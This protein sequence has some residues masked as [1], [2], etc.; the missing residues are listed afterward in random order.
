MRRSCGILLHT[1]TCAEWLVDIL[2]EHESPARLLSW[3]S[4]L[5]ATFYFHS[6]S[7]PSSTS[8]III[9]TQE[10]TPGICHSCSETCVRFT[11][12]L[13]AIA[14][15]TLSAGTSVWA[16]DIIACCVSM[17]IRYI[18][19]ALVHIC[20]QHEHQQQ[21]WEQHNKL[22]KIKKYLR[23]LLQMLTS[24]Q[25]WYNCLCSVCYNGMGDWILSHQIGSVVN[26][27]ITET[28]LTKT[29]IA[30][31]GIQRLNVLRG[32]LGQQYFSYKT[33]NVKL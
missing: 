10:T 12:T 2:I 19:R 16:N 8:D 13:S 15:K 30:G 21:S 29:V 33:R 22:N 3:L 23:Y 14:C 20:R 4:S 5:S 32:L 11:C 17:A 1:C 25:D 26:N 9:F 31:I 28:L 24:I 7:F 6:I 27:F 18:Q